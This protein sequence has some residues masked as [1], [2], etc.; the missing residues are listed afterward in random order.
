MSS[1]D[2]KS[3]QIAIAIDPLSE[4][5]NKTIEW[6]MDNILRTTDE[7]H[8]IMI[9]VLDC[10]F[11]E[12]EKMKAMEKMVDKIKQNGF[13]VKSHVFKTDSTHACNVL[14]DYLDTHAMDCLIMGSRNLSGWKKFFMGSFSD[15]VQS[16]V[17]CPVLID[18]VNL[19]T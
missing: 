12:Q 8:A 2:K 5:A 1:D 4:E 9:M 3:R 11:G 7:I 14:I 6:A 19:A 13:Q 15:Y 16:H 18:V 17:H 10:E